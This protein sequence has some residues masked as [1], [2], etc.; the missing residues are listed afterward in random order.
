MSEEHERAAALRHAFD[1]E[2]T[3]DNTF[4]DHDEPRERDNRTPQAEIARDQIAQRDRIL[5]DAGISYEDYRSYADARLDELIAGP[6]PTGS[7]W[8]ADVSAAVD[9]AAAAAAAPT[10]SHA[11]AQASHQTSAARARA[12]S[13]GQDHGR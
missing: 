5:A 8:S 2:Q 13:R 4:A 9:E 12:T 3:A 10:K 6:V 11:S 7:R 1:R